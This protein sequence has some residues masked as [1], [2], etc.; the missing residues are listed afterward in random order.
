MIL[1]LPGGL[2]PSFSARRP[3]PW[4]AVAAPGALAELQRAVGAVG[5]VT[6]AA[7][8][9][10]GKGQEAAFSK[11][12]AAATETKAGVRV[13]LS[14]GKAVQLQ[15]IPARPNDE[16]SFVT[17]HY[18]GFEP[19]TE[20]VWVTKEAWESTKQL[21]L[22]RRSGRVTEVGNEPHLNGTG[23][24]LFARQNDC[25]RVFEDCYPGFQL[26]RV[27]AGQLQLLKQVRLEN[28][29]VL[30][31]HWL[32]P[33]KLSLELGSIEELM[34]QRGNDAKVRRLPFELTLKP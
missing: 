4:P 19:K 33:G 12:A 1:A 30:D 17:Y 21:L 27:Q 9:A 7:A 3:A 20:L 28:Y 24:L 14:S 23:T 5:T 11:S 34:N 15:N 10:A 22:N 6:P 8:G 25:F 2:A 29:F 32:A 18:R 16:T 31:G 13:Q 26:W